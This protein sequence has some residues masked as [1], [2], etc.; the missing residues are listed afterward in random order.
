MKR[1]IIFSVILLHSCFSVFGQIDE[2]GCQVSGKEIPIIYNRSIL[3]QKLPEM[4]FQFDS[5]RALSE[6]N[7]NNAEA[8]PWI[9]NDGFRIYYSKQIGLYSILCQSERE[10]LDS[11]FTMPQ[12]LSVNFPYTDNFSPWLTKDELNIYFIIYETD[13]NRSTT[14]YHASRNKIGEDFISPIKVN[15]SGYVSGFVSGQSFTEDMLQLFIFNSRESPRILIFNMLSHNDYALADTLNMPS[16]YKPSPGQLGNN[17]LKYYLALEDNDKKVLLYCFTRESVKGKFNDIYYLNNELINDSLFRNIQPTLSSDGDYF[18][19]TRAISNIY[20]FNDLYFAYNKP[21]NSNV[22]QLIGNPSILKIYP[23]PSSSLI[24]ITFENSK[25]LEIENISIFT[26][27]GILIQNFSINSDL[28]EIN[29]SVKDYAPG[30]YLC[31]LKTRK[32]LMS[33]K[34]IIN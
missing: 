28:K 6:V 26:S 20:G 17:D 5:V 18:V 27:S 9:S 11:N 1:I 8:Y 22:N 12:I 13:G 25:D 3:N 19:F 16:G 21:H 4:E 31:T 29:I 30:S 14:L 34:F 10:N 2:N 33:S 24:T 7:T 32:G 23:N 15:L